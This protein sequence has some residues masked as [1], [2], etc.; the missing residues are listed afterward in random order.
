MLVYPFVRFRG[1]ADMRHK[2]TSTGCFKIYPVCV[3]QITEFGGS[4]LQYFGEF[5]AGNIE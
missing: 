3:R 4:A 5:F 2:V 1:E